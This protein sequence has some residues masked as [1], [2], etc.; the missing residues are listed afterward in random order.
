MKKA[1]TTTKVELAAT[2]GILNPSRYRTRTLP[3]AGA[4]LRP[5]DIG[6]VQAELDI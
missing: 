6:Q 3:S 2:S 5:E 4:P 1:R